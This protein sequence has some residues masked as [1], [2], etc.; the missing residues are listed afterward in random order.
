[1][2]EIGNISNSPAKIN[3]GI[4]N[5]FKF[6]GYPS[7]PVNFSLVPDIKIIDFLTGIFKMFNLTAFQDNDGIIQVK[8]LDDFY[9]SSTTVHDITPFVDKTETITDT[10]LPFKMI[11]LLLNA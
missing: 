9:A 1:M 2:C 5:A 6:S 8:T 7:V 11:G 4:G 3:N 10:V